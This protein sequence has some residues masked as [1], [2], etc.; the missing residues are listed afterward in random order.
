MEY[1]ANSHIKRLGVI[2]FLLAWPWIILDY[3]LPAYARNELQATAFDIGLYL[4]L[5]SITMA[6]VRLWIGSLVDRYGR[7]QFLIAGICC[8]ILA[9]LF[10]GLATGIPFVMIASV[11][12]GLGSALFWIPAYAIVADLSD[13][14]QRGATYGLLTGRNQQGLF[15]GTFMGFALIPFLEGLLSEMSDPFRWAWKGT[16]LVYALLGLYALFLG[17]QGLK[18]LSRPLKVVPEQEQRP[19][20]GFPPLLIVIF[21]TGFG[22]TLLTPLLILYLLDRFALTIPELAFS[23]VPAAVISAVLPPFAGRL[24][25][26]IGYQRSIAIGLLTSAVTFLLIPWAPT[27]FVLVLLW[28]IEAACLTLA[29]PAQ[30]ALVAAW[31]KENKRGTAYGYYTMAYRLGATLGPLL[32]GWIYDRVNPA[33]PFLISS[34]LLLIGAGLI[35]TYRQHQGRDE[36]APSL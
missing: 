25:D 1:P 6:F 24:A 28:A 33:Y 19:P 32:G 35:L 30:Q 13:P 21:L 16:F 8:Y 11:F 34:A 20:H 36:R 4:A 27:I 29:S 9:I 23:Y 2:A 5:F 31:S 26:K 14:S 18:G 12:H 3:F 7:R 22:Q 17:L 15:V 10:Y